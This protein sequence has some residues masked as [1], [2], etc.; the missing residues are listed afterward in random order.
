[1]ASL[2]MVFV[3]GAFVDVLPYG[4]TLLEESLAFMGSAEDEQEM[5]S[6]D[7]LVRHSKDPLPL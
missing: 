4:S 6:Q 5:V 7:T 2:S 3:C 1:M